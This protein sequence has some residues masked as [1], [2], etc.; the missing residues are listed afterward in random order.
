[1]PKV[2]KK[3]RGI[4]LPTVVVFL[5]VLSIIGITGMRNTVLEQ[6]MSSN[7]QDLNHAFQLAESGIVR[8][9]SDAGILN[10]ETSREQYLTLSYTSFYDS[11]GQDIALTARSYYRGQVMPEGDTLEYVNTLNINSAHVFHV[12]TVGGFNSATSTHAQGVAI[13]G[14]GSD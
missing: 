1:M 4:A 11:S 6:K 13:L 10:T 5:I 14:P 7:M 12:Q 3:E 8:A 9:A 2:Q